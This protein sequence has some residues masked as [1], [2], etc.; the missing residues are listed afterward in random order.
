MLFWQNN[1]RLNN[2]RKTAWQ[3]HFHWYNRIQ[4]N[5]CIENWRGYTKYVKSKTHI[6]KRLIYTIIDKTKPKTKIKRKGKVNIMKKLLSVLLALSI[7]LSFSISTGLANAGASTILT[8]TFTTNNGNGVLEIDEVEEQLL[9]EN[10]NY[11][12]FIAEFDKSFFRCRIS[13]WINEWLLISILIQG[14][15]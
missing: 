7:A 6:F 10:P 14:N 15:Y 13:L 4:T 12:Q 11:Q 5:V 3:N 2:F 9:L 1:I 8:I